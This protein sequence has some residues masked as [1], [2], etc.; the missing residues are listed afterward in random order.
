MHVETDYSDHSVNTLTAILHFMNFKLAE[1]W[2][3]WSA[4]MEGHIHKV[5]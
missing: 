5:N 1:R 3:I 2:S 4:E